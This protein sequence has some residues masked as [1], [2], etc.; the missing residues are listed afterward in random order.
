MY[1]AHR[2]NKLPEKHRGQRLKKKKQ[3]YNVCSLIFIKIL[4]T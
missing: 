3:I 1:L 2:M 4:N